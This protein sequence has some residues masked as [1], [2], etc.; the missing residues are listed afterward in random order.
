MNSS[1]RSR[2]LFTRPLYLSIAVAT[3]IE[4]IN[5]IIFGMLLPGEGS[6]LSTFLWTVGIGGIALGSV[7]GV[8]IDIVVI[9]TARGRDAF[10]ATL[11]LT[12]L[13][14]GLVAKL[15]TWNMGFAYEGLGASEWP[16]LYLAVGAFLAAAGGWLLAW[17]LF[18]REGNAWLA[19]R[20]L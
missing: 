12:L 5:F 9:G 6:T 14:L 8:L 7:L 4:F 3:T 10:W 1:T 17:L 2:L 16:M 18:S 19:R 13:T 20:G 15:F 11:I